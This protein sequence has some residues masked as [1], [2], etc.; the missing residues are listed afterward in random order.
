MGVASFYH[1]L[2]KVRIV[3][4]RILIIR[5]SSLGDIVLTTPVLETVRQSMPDTDIGYITKRGYADI[6]RHDPRIHQFFRLENER[7][8]LFKLAREIRRWKPDIVLD[9]HAN[10]RS[11]LLCTMLPGRVLRYDKDRT[12]RRKLVER[13]TP[14]KPLQHTVDLYLETL[15]PLNLP[16]TVR[17][18]H[19]MIPKTLHPLRDRLPENP[20]RVVGVNPGAIHFTKRWPYYPELVQHLLRDESNTVVLFGGPDDPNLKAGRYPLGHPRLIDTIGQLSLS[21]LAGAIRACDI[22]VTNDSGP[23]HIAVA[24][25]TP[26]VAIFGGTVPELGF[27]PLGEDDAVVQRPLSCRPC[28][29]HGQT[30]CP[31][32]HFDCMR[33]ISVEHVL[34]QIN[35]CPTV[36]TKG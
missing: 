12:S 20:G 18:P 32:G 6:L 34:R 14:R 25:E 17:K 31:L 27:W 24:V 36:E 21:E 30:S 19:L 8:G 5:F 15:R 22:F 26:V 11:H 4:Q 3:S 10:L 23:M 28:H 1:S 13:K 9:L 29:L 33:Q 35:Q 7:F 16:M 2:T